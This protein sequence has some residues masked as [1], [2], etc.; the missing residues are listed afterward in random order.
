MTPMRMVVVAE[1]AKRASNRVV[2]ADPSSCRVDANRRCSSGHSSRW[3]STAI[4]ARYGARGRKKHPPKE[5][6]IANLPQ[7]ENFNAVVL[8]Q[9]HVIVTS[10]VRTIRAKSAYH[11][12]VVVYAWNRGR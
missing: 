9:T 7:C 10:W 11:A 6:N 4:A 3:G 1:L 12:F 8:V 2:T 5:I